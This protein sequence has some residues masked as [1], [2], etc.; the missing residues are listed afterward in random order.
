MFRHLPESSQLISEA[1]PLASGAARVECL[2]EFCERDGRWT[3][4]E[5][6]DLHGSAWPIDDSSP[7]AVDP[8]LAHEVRRLIYTMNAIESL[9][10]TLRK[11]VCVRGHFPNDEAAVKL[12]YLAIR[13]V[14][15]KW[16]R[17]PQYWNRALNQFSIMFEGRLPA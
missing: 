17:Q 12:L 10:S 11:V 8:D 14:E 1:S 9:N 7:M 3:L 6:R 2:F 15:K 4:L 13:N 16:T 5:R